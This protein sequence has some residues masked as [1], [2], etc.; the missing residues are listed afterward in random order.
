ME[1]KE[2]ITTEEFL[3]KEST[4]LPDPN[5]IKAQAIDIIE[6]SKKVGLPVSFI[7]DNYQEI[8]NEKGKL[9]EIGL[10]EH[11]LRMDGID[12]AKRVPFSPV[13]PVHSG[14]LVSASMRLQ[15]NN[16]KKWALHELKFAEAMEPMSI[17][18]TAY[19]PT[20]PTEIT[21]EEISLR[22]SQMKQ[23]DEK[24]ITDWLLRQQ[25]IA[26]RGQ[27]FATKV[28]DGVSYLPAWMIEFMLTGG[29]AQIGNKTAQNIGV[30][31][32]R[33]YSKTKAGRLALRTMGW[34][35]GAITRA[36][37]GLQHRVL[38]E[39]MQRRLDNT[40]RLGPNNEIEFTVPKEGWAASIAKGWGAVVIE[41]AS[42]TAGGTITKGLNKI[43]GRL[44]VGGKIISGVRNEW[45]KLSADNTIAKFTEKIFT[46]GG[47][48]GIIGEIGEERLNTIMASVFSIDDYGT[49]PDSNVMQRLGAGIK[50]DILNF[51]V[52][53]A[54]LSFP[55][56]VRYTGIKIAGRLEKGIER[57]VE[58][59][60]LITL[61]EL[62]WKDLQTKA[63]EFG[64]K[65]FQ[66]RAELEKQIR[67]AGVGPEIFAEEAR[68]RELEKPGE[69]MP[70]EEL[71]RKEI[72]ARRRAEVKIEAEAEL[73]R[74]E[75]EQKEID[76]SV[77]AQEAVEATKHYLGQTPEVDLTVKE[78]TEEDVGF[79][80]NFMHK[81]GI[82]DKEGYEP[83]GKKDFRNIYKYLQMPEDIRHTH[84]E[85]DA[86]YMVQKAREVDFAVL[87]TEFLN[88]MT[89]YFQLHKKDQ[90]IVDKA[91]I[92]AEQSPEESYSRE[93]LKSMGLTK[94]QQDGFL[95]ARKT[96]MYASNLLISRMK[97]SGVK[98]EAI[99]D[100]KKRIKKYIPHKWYGNWAIVAY[101]TTELD[102]K[103]K[104][105]VDFVSATN[106][107]DRFNE[108][109]RV[110]KLYPDAEVTVIKRTKLPYEAYQNA[111]PWAVRSLLDEVIER[112]R[113]DPETGTDLEEVL[114]T[115]QKE[116]GFGMH[117]I[118]RK[119]I[120]GWTEDLRRP[121]AQYLTGLAGFISKTEAIKAFSKSLSQTRKK[122]NLHRYTIDYINYT[123]GHHFEFQPIKRAF[124]T[125]YLWGNIKSAALNATQN[126]ILGWPVLSKHT[127]LALPRLI[128]AMARTAIPGTL[129]VD[130]KQFLK[131]LE[132]EGY[133]VPQLSQ[134]IA[135]YTGSPVLY[136]TRG[137]IE[138]TMG[139]LDVFK[140]MEQFNRKSMA[141]A[142]YNA[143]IQNPHEAAFAIEEAHFHYGKGNR[144]VLARG[145]ISPVMVFRSWGI[146]YMQWLKNEIKA[147]RI[148]PFAKS[149]SALVLLGGIAGL[150]GWE[151]IK[152]LWE[153][154]FGQTPET[155]A[156]E[157]LGSTAGELLMRGTPSL[158]PIG[159]GISFTG[160]V[161][162]ADILPTELKDIPGVVG[163]IKTRYDR[164]RKD[165]QSE[166]WIRALEDASPEFLRNPLA[167]YRIHK[168]GH[169][170]RS[171]SP[172][173][174]LTSGK[175]VRLTKGEAIAKAVGFQ[176]E[177][178]SKNWRLAD[179]IRE[180]GEN[181]LD[182]NQ[183]W[184]NRYVLGIIQ[185]DFDASN[186]VID[187][188][189]AFNNKMDRQGT[190]EKKLD[191][192]RW[193]SLISSRMKAANIPPKH[194]WPEAKELLEKWEGKSKE[195]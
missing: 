64:I 14:F 12:W 116:K 5:Q 108:R 90:A 167:A 72:F 27:T 120:P 32:L 33:S 30:K 31:L 134:E 102:E 175:L 82:K 69:V 193:K 77:A 136:H 70:E 8:K 109:N 125:Y 29:L 47:W 184:A 49:G 4:T 74:T 91:L 41:A 124:Y 161:G 146:N 129:R 100:F 176:P 53:L 149:M 26:E 115:L 190:P 80:R 57:E 147:K 122:P 138:R 13:G 170:T 68:L 43:L 119:D 172:F 187:E 73:K 164:L 88:S 48:H 168:Y 171:G 117:F 165:I 144:P 99:D 93:K 36:S 192:K 140:H 111:V 9:D 191:E 51:P 40:I 15:K 123:M 86:T 151:I 143:G 83:L 63:R 156:R 60:R 135:G 186:E 58:P 104:P 84:P 37:L 71:E 107:T 1:I 10:K 85:F 2:I 141:L 23:Q 133:L 173:V 39:I 110:Q 103:G 195:E 44:P 17:A 126:F 118:K 157:V 121:L 20:E 7:E 106:F 101:S 105:K 65:P 194:L 25:E 89:S 16:Y 62:S 55:A 113:L 162:Q 6:I 127:D 56:G 97:E 54:V 160:S 42:E 95:A 59:E 98:K 181:E 158:I 3:E 154:L 169:F 79:I 52:E 178:L 28:F 183:N 114:N 96:L 22:A 130:E 87:N 132:K 18:Y 61:S 145:M 78:P 46:A 76:K 38:N 92:K 19:P 148:K 137:K 188:I 150:P 67:D 34:A 24:F 94:T 185:K 112:A 45:L 131:D 139:L 153:E 182:R 166:D 81:W 189:V 180:L 66:K 163:D 75:N 11:V 142:L 155:M 152:K 159:E 21:P 179:A 128:Q 50:Q 35:G 177:K 174:D